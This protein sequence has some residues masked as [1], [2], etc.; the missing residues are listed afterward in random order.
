MKITPRNAQLYFSS[1]LSLFWIILGL[2]LGMIT[3]YLQAHGFSNSE[4]GWILA[5]VNLTSTLLQPALAAIFE[6]SGQPLRRCIAACYALIAVLA[7]IVFLIPMPTPALLAFLWAMFALKSSMQ[8]SV[9]SLVQSFEQIGCPVNFG[10]ARGIGSL[11]YGVVVAIA[12]AALEKISPLMLPAAYIGFVLAFVLLLVIPKMGDRA[13]VRRKAGSGTDR[14]ALRQPAFI[15]FLVASAFFSLNAV[16]NGSFMLQIMQSLG[17]N[18][19]E[20][21]LATS[22]AAWLEFPAMLLYSRFCKRFGE[23]RLLVLSGWAWF[24]KNG[25]I[26]LAR[27]PE[28]IYAAQMLQFFSFALFIPGVVRYIAKI[29]PEDVFLRG[30]SLYGSAYT[31]GSVVAVFFGG[32]LMD[33]A[34]VYNTLL[35]AQT[36]SF[37]G[38][39]LLTL[40][41]RLSSSS[42]E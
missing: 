31:A 41:V 19:A 37:L 33:A 20:Y 5:A 14:A 11:V 28:A 27:S 9:N 36:F 16:M 30:Q 42:R 32:V 23:N 29:L 1:I 8:S 12:G 13:P 2:M 25:L 26:L 38:A 15:L 39:I 10:V 21:G 18:S 22:I 4:I 35:I 6:R 17:G 34:G 24:A 3:V 40:S 7:A